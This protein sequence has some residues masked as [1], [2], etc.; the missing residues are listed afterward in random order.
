M[1]QGHARQCAHHT[2]GLYANNV[3][4]QVGSQE[5]G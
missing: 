1:E 3:T 5:L 4:L 2:S